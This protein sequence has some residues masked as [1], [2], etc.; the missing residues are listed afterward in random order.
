MPATSTY[1]RTPSRS[2]SR[3]HPLAC[4]RYIDFANPTAEQIADAKKHGIDLYDPLV[5][6]ELQKLQKEREFGSEGEGEEESEGE[7]ESGDDGDGLSSSARG[8]GERAGL[9][10]RRKG[11]NK[12]DEVSIHSWQQGHR[13][14]IRT[15]TLSPTSTHRTT[16]CRPC[17]AVR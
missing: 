13:L 16:R 8:G 10:R 7:G 3:A 14:W 2:P 12:V 15:L 5:V 6:R 4:P 17:T 11:G 1:S 9:S